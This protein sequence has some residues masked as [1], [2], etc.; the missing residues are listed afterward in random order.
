MPRQLN[1]VLYGNRYFG[2]TFNLTQP[3]KNA[4]LVSKLDAQTRSSI[5][6]QH[7]WTE[8][9]IQN[10]IDSDKPE[11][12]Q[13]VTARCQPKNFAPVRNFQPGELPARI[14]MLVDG[15]VAPDTGKRSTV[16]Q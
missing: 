1:P 7:Q 2:H 8:I 16:R 11:S 9:F 4:D 5:D 14:R 3:G 13:V 10:D 12:D 15:R 6:F